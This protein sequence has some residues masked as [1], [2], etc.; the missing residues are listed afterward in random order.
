VF[1]DTHKWTQKIVKHT[2]AHSQ[3]QTE[4]QANSEKEKQ[5][6]KAPS[7]QQ[8]RVHCDTE[9]K[10][11]PREMTDHESGDN[12]SK[13]RLISILG[14]LPGRGVFAAGDQAIPHTYVPNEWVVVLRSFHHMGAKKRNVW[15]PSS[16]LL[17]RGQ[18]SL[19]TVAG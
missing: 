18:V 1:T 9:Q 5:E 17:V 13:S 7:R 6:Q 14:P 2:I 10:R 8:E 16:H 4:R 12:H 19:G 3:K 15:L 11:S